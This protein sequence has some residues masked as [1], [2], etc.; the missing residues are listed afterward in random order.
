[1]KLGSRVRSDAEVSKSIGQ[2]TEPTEAHLA[3]SD[4][5]VIVSLGASLSDGGAN[6]LH[7]GVAPFNVSANTYQPLETCQYNLRSSDG[8][9]LMKV[10]A[11][12]NSIIEYIAVSSKISKV[13]NQH[14]ISAHSIYWGEDNS[15]WKLN[16]KFKQ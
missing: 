10:A 7:Y 1:M 13:K 15:I 8:R 11:K 2:P 6:I 14:S 3:S 9:C 4:A 16:V 5:A 12:P